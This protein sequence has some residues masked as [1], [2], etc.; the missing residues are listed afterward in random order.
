MRQEGFAAAISLDLVVG[1][2][3]TL[4]YSLHQCDPTLPVSGTAECSLPSCCAAQHPPL[5]PIVLCSR[6]TVLSSPLQQLVLLE[7][8]RLP[9]LPLCCPT[10]PSACACC[11]SCQVLLQEPLLPFLLPLPSPMGFLLN[12]KRAF[13]Q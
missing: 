4:E 11:S 1:G 6:F 9:T 13:H 10:K 3:V 5:L 8:T 7:L 2:T 12:H